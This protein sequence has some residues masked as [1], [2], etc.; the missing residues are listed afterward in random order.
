MEIGVRMRWEK[1]LRFR[2]L[3]HLATVSLDAVSVERYGLNIVELHWR[4]CFLCKNSI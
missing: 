2:K 4:W 1:Q 3:F